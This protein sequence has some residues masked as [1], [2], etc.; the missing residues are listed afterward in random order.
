MRKG[1]VLISVKRQTIW[2]RWILDLRLVAQAHRR[3]EH[4]AR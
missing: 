4:K 3:P 1:C 2:R